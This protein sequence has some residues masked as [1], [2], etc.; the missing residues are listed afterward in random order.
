MKAGRANKATTPA[1]KTSLAK[2]LKAEALSP[3][4]VDLASPVSADNDIAVVSTAEASRVTVAVRIKPTDGA[5]TIMRF[6]PRGENA[7][8]F[9]HLDGTKAGEDAK[10][11]AYDHVFDQSESQTDVYSALGPRVLEHVTTGHNA[12]VFAYGQTGSGKTYTMLGTAEEPGLIPRLCDGLF[13]EAGLATW[14]ISL[15]FFEIYN[16][17][18]VDLL[19]VPPDEG[20]AASEDAAGAKQEWLGAGLDPRRRVPVVNALRVRE[21]AKL[22]VYV[23]GLTKLPVRTPDDVAAA[24]ER[25]TSLRAV[26]ETAMNAESS[27]SHAV[28]QLTFA[29]GSSGD[30]TATLNL[31]D[32]AGSENVGRSRSHEDHSRLQEAKSINK[33]LLG[34]GKCISQLAQ[35]GGGPA[36]LV[37]Y[38]D[39]VLTWLLKDALGGNAHTLML[40][41]VDPSAENA[42]QTLTTL[43]YAD[44]AKK[45]TTRPVE[46]ID[47]T[48]K[49]VRELNEQVAAL[50]DEA[51][52]ASAAQAAARA[53]AAEATATAKAAAEAAAAAK[54]ER[55]AAMAAVYAARAEGERDRAEVE[56]W[57]REAAA[58]EAELRE[59][60]E[61]L[62]AEAAKA[63][64]AAAEASKAA[65]EAKPTA[66][67]EAKSKSIMR[68][69]S[70]LI[71]KGFRSSSTAATAD[72]SAS[73]SQGTGGVPDAAVVAAMSRQE[74]LAFVK[75][76]KEERKALCVELGIEEEP[77]RADAAD[78]AEKATVATA[79]AAA[80]VATSGPSGAQ[81]AAGAAPSSAFQIAFKC[82]GFAVT[83]NVASEA[84]AESVPS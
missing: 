14:T 33:S 67:A 55:E 57:K 35:G 30:R 5:K 76:L 4:P 25:G 29:E 71:A 2:A 75:R 70:R 59:R 31:V 34:L 11:F 40:C 41:A 28:V 83:L 32:L 15:S 51:N 18:V 79:A 16:E 64:A 6:G 46:N 53:Q 80:A 24:L 56:R 21:H 54:A 7:L 8:R 47:T 78:A 82:L 9:G 22:G 49:M 50:R 72:E 45:I 36:G 38:R 77:K 19:L 61:A 81:P 48:K 23:E 66:V 60:E 3:T 69:P 74:K 84:P 1:H 58:R 44:Q 37:P 39:S 73:A 68:S 20:P 17:Q 42:E 43:R 65:I 27:R 52:A 13:R 63:A 10:G 26:A 62:Q 12:S